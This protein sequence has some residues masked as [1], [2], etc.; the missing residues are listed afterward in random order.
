MSDD[1][2]QIL[3]DAAT[4]IHDNGDGDKVHAALWEA[5][6]ILATEIKRLRVET[7]NQLIDLREWTNARMDGGE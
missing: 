3:I 7:D 5:V 4:K 6:V 2:L 1:P